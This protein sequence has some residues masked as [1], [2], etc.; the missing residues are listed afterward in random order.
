MKN[1]KT[2]KKDFVA[3]NIKAPIEL[4]EA[5]KKYC[6]GADIDMSKLI[7]LLIRNHLRL[8][9]ASNE[10]AGTAETSGNSQV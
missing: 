4:K 9:G 8:N 6:D 5:F 2:L 1:N 10:P 3:L 7:R